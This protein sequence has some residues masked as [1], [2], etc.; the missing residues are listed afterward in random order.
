MSDPWLP[1][2]DITLPAVTLH[3]VTI[4][5]RLV[6]V[7]LGYELRNLTNQRVPISAGSYSLGQS[8]RWRLHWTFRN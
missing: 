4:G 2:D 7:D 5:F 8:N 6:G 3:H 1:G